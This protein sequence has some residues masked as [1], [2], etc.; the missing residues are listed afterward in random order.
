MF[1]QT[2]MLSVFLSWLIISNMCH[3]MLYY[4]HR[5][6]INLTDSVLAWNIV[7]VMMLL[8]VW[9]VEPLPKTLEWVVSFIR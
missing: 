3:V 9:M 1:I 4:G 8:W 6:G 5:R 7:T 2:Q